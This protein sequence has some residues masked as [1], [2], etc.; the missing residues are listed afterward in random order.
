MKKRWSIPLRGLI[1]W[2]IQHT[3]H[4]GEVW[5]FTGWLNV[6]NFINNYEIKTN[7]NWNMFMKMINKMHLENRVNADFKIFPQTKDCFFSALPSLF[8]E[9]LTAF[10]PSRAPCVAQ[11]HKTRQCT[12]CRHHKWR[13]LGHR[14]ESAKWAHSSPWKHG[15]AF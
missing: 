9:M 13:D 8:L 11:C 14:K 3:L 12:E 6:H 7:K 5:R 10:S 2:I 4:Q 15:S 1:N